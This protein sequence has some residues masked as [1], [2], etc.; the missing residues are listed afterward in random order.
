[1]RASTAILTSPVLYIYESWIRSARVSV[2]L[3][4][5]RARARRVRKL[6]HAR[7]RRL[8]LGAIVARHERVPRDADLQRGRAARGAAR[9]RRKREPARRAARERVRGHAEPDAHDQRA[10]RDA[11]RGVSGIRRCE[12]GGCAPRRR[13]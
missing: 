13:G 7:T 2:P 8:L 9:V 3:R 11:L 5:V 6:K 4:R 12:N 1:M 10:R